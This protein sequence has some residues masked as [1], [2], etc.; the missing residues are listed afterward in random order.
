MMKK[1]TD[2]EKIFTK[3]IVGKDLV[4]RMYKELLELNNNNNKNTL[5]LK[6]DKINI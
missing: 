6:I 5:I 3:C 4:S 1:Q 2:C